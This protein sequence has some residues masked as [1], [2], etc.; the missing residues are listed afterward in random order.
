MMYE[1]LLK[2][3]INIKRLIES[4]IVYISRE[5]SDLTMCRRV[6]EVS[7]NPDLDLLYIRFNGD[8][9]SAYGEYVGNYIHVFIQDKKIVAIEI[10]PFSKFLKK[11]KI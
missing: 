10:T 5:V 9:D 3:N 7:L 11:L 4:I 2:L 6:L 1:N 8:K